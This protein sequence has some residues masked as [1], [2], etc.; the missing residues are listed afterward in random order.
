ME[1]NSKVKVKGK[2]TVAQNK[3]VKKEVKKS[4]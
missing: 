1:T 4:K 2:Y 3:Q